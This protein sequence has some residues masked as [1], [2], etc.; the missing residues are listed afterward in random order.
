MKNDNFFFTFS[1]VLTVIFYSITNVYAQDYS[2]KAKAASSFTKKKNNDLYK[3]FPFKDS[4]SF[5][6]AKRGYIAPLP[7]KGIV[8]D[9]NG[10][11]VWDYNAF[12]SFIKD[13]E[14]SPETVNPSLWRQSQL[15][16]YSGLFEVVPGIYQ[17][18]GADLS[19]M[20]IVEAKDGIHIYDPL[21]S[22]ETA[23]YALD[24]Y[25][26]HRPKK[27]VKA[28]FY[29]H[30]HVDHFGGVLGVT[31]KE[32][33]KSGKVKIYAPE[34]F[35][36]HAIEENVYAGIAM[37]RRANYMYGNLLSPSTTGQIGAG[38]GIT[39]STGSTGIIEP[40]NVITTTGQKETIDG[41]EY[42]FVMAQGSEAPSEMMWYL[43]DYKVLNTAE[44]AVHNMHNLYTLRGAKT[45][46]AALWPNYLNQVLQMFGDQAEAAI[47]MHHWPV[48]GKDRI[49]QHIK[50]QRDVYKFMHDQT[51]HHANMGATMNE[52]PGLINMPESLVNQWGTHGYYGSKSHN[53]R[54]VYNF[55]LGYFDGNPAHLNPLPP[56]NVGEK[57]IEAFGGAD[58]V[59]KL[60]KKAFD[61]GE[62]RWASEL[63][64]H[65]IF[66]QPNLQD[67][68]LLQ[69]D[70]LEQMGYQSE[71]GTWRNFYLSGAKEL[72]DG[73]NKPEIKQVVNKQIIANMTMDLIFGYMGIELDAE[74][75]K[76]KKITVNW[77]LTD[78]NENYTMFL[79]NSVLNYWPNSEVSDADATIIL[80]RETL[81][82]FISGSISFTKAVKQKKIKIEGKTLKLIALLRCLDN[83]QKNMYFNIVTP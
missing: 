1:F 26:Q 32:E 7:N 55:Y 57:Y 43:S 77:K 46:D 58:A 65:L 82:E 74:K 21:I 63:L 9:T 10:K 49:N 68:K 29:T 48:W 56:Q 69:A 52:L 18:R 24:L 3:S 39:T 5:K 19:N 54:A 35:L 59:M 40:T 25:Y 2:T 33:V 30:S 23:K 41:L 80:T 8:K 17:V 37:G 61:N 79:E 16:M 73:V 38:L 83:L 76:G 27:P 67:A 42:Q 70:V 4:T 11:I 64:N 34:G 78:V 62:Y 50:S 53:V 45:R 66:A 15:L 81:N 36:Y 12:K 60:G 75:A 44:D 71:N 51:L 20:T 14:Q 13:G 22:E 28:V 31:S 72:R 47:G 6:E